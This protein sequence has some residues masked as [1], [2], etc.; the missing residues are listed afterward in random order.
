[1]F[2]VIVIMEMEIFR[3]DFRLVYHAIQF[4]Y[5]YHKCGCQWNELNMIG[6][7]TLK[8]MINIAAVSKMVVFGRGAE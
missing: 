7:I 4:A 5:R 1:M 8:S 2:S 6:S 3:I